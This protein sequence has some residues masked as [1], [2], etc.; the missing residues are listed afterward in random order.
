MIL[1]DHKIIIHYH[2]VYGHQT[3]QY[4]PTCFEWIVLKNLLDSLVMWYWFLLTKFTPC[5]LQIKIEQ[6]LNQLSNSMDTGHLNKTL[7]YLL[8]NNS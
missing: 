8:I 1:R 5:S 4:I 3:W 7:S 6:L 2:S